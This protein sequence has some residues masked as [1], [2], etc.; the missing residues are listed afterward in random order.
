[1]ISLPPRRRTLFR[2]SR[3][4]GL[5]ASALAALA[6]SFSLSDVLDDVPYTTPMW[7]HSDPFGFSVLSNVETRVSAAE[8]SLVAIAGWHDADTNR[9]AVLDAGLLSVSNSAA[10][11]YAAATGAVAQV[12]LVYPI[13][14]NALG[15]ASSAGV[16]ALYARSRADSAYNYALYDHGA[17]TSAQ[18]AADSAYALALQASY[19]SSPYTLLSR[20]EPGERSAYLDLAYG[21]AS[22]L[23]G[24]VYSVYTPTQAVWRVYLPVVTNVL[25]GPLAWSGWFTR[26]CTNVSASVF[27][28]PFPYPLPAGAEAY[29][30]AEAVGLGDGIA[31]SFQLS[32]LTNAGNRVTYVLTRHA[33]VGDSGDAVAETAALQGSDLAATNEIPFAVYAGFGPTGTVTFTRLGVGEFS[34]T[35]LTAVLATEA[36]V[37]AAIEAASPTVLTNILFG[38]TFSNGQYWAKI[39]LP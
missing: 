15:V 18:A 28:M 25:G 10:I 34:V 9:F 32:A 39:I 5:A 37:A 7:S 12:S 26:V 36:G 11:S 35:N 29:A 30:W 21:N 13:A 2:R 31:G 20:P 6:A 17:V 27:P 33:T 16:A 1:M 4:V 38:A 19:D 23:S 24:R 8:V 22:S 3:I 14:T